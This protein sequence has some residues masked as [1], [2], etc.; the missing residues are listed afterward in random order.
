V[1]PLE[2]SR[3]FF[4]AVVVVMPAVMMAVVAVPWLVVMATAA[5]R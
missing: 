3:A 2:V 5:N 4:V 1:R